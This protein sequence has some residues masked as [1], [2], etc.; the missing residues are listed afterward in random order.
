MSFPIYDLDNAPE[1]SKPVLRE[2]KQT[3]GFVP[4]IAG[5][6]AASPTLLA[7]FFSVFKNAHSGSLDEAQIQ[8]LLL[9]NAVTNRSTWPV[10]FHTFLA[11][12][13]GVSAQDVQAIR[14]GTQPADPKHAALSGLAKRLI[15]TR[16]HATQ[17][18]LDSFLG[19]GFTQPQ[20][21]EVIL[22]VAASTITNY[23]AT[24]A[25]PA[26]EEAFQAHAWTPD[27]VR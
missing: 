19:A 21:L 6:L 15:E 5:A 13:N 8:V 10:A 2:L 1:K 18:D 22:V 24:V 7:G 3:F 12:K 16:G 23:V 20:V 17:T 14:H 25:R 26:L 11:L 4:N 9:T 27:V